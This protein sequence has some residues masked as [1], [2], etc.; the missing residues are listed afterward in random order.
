MSTFGHLF[1][2]QLPSID[3]QNGICAFQVPSRRGRQV[4]K[5]SERWP[6]AHVGAFRFGQLVVTRTCRGWVGTPHSAEDTLSANC[7]QTH[8]LKPVASETKETVSRP[9]AICFTHP[10]LQGRGTLSQRP[11]CQRSLNVLQDGRRQGTNRHRSTGGKE[12]FVQN[13]G[14]K[15]SFW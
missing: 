6:R 4:V 11:S 2:L 14:L 12:S 1:P 3:P 9:L 13:R 7:I 8:Y 10:L 15:S 5:Q